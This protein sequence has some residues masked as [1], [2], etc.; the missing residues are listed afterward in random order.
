[1]TASYTTSGRYVGATPASTE[2][3]SAPAIGS[4]EKA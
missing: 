1:M 3:M 4:M 2:R